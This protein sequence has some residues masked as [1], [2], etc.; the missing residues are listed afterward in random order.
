MG[1]VYF[2]NAASNYG[3]GFWLPTMALV[4]TICRPGSLPRS[5]TSSGRSRWCTGGRVQNNGAMANRPIAHMLLSGTAAAGGIALINS[6]GNLA[7]FAAPYMMGYLKDMTG[8]FSA[9]LLVVSILPF[10]SFILG[11][12]PWP[13]PGARTPW[14]RPNE[15]PESAGC[16][17]SAVE[18]H[19]QRK[20]LVK[21]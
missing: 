1:L 2:G 16:C 11:S 10:L 12:R 3:L 8:G 15:P 18:R 4:S 19:D 7:G 9:G 14:R 21:L 13:Q 17:G 6:I 20:R 5:P